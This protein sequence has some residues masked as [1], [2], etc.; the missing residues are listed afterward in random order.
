MNSFIYET[1][2]HTSETSPCAKASAEEVVS[3]Y[4]EIGYSGIIITDHFICRGEEM[5]EPDKWKEAVNNLCMGY[6]KAREIGEK[7][8]LQVFFGWEYSRVPH[9]GTD[10][11]TYGLDASWLL[12]HPEVATMRISDYC[13]LVHSD[14][15]FITQAHPF[16]ESWY[17]EMIRLLPRKVDAVEVINASLSEFI[18]GIAEKYA[19]YYSLIK[20]AGSD[21]HF[22]SKLKQVAGLSFDTRLQDIHSFISAVKDNKSEIYFKKFD[23]KAES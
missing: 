5:A 11:L 14:G 12:E 21:N 2:V 6:N 17:I 18:Y 9:S 10:L 20:S 13:D 3:F 4:K 23:T 19:D 15:G 22:G 1:H 16:R 7:I 8:G